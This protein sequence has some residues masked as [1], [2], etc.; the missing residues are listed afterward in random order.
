MKSKGGKCTVLSPDGQLPDWLRHMEI[1]LEEL[2][3]GV[4]VADS[5]SR[6]VF[7]NEALLRLG[8]YQRKE[9]QGGTPDTIFPPED[10]PFLMQQRAMTERFG[11]ATL[12]VDVAQGD[13]IV[14]YT[15]GLTEVFDS[16]GEM[17]GVEGLQRFVRETAVLPFSEMKEGILDRVAAWREGPPTDGVSLITVEVR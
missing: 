14:L 11:E 17:L 9:V 2:N 3:E 10:I 7:V 6:V 1:I 12:D 5:N 13:R 4:I 8:G 15:D 16:R